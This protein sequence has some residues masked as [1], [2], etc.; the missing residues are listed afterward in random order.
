MKK[1]GV[2]TMLLTSITVNLCAQQ[3]ASDKAFEVP[4]NIIIHRKFD[5]NLDKGNKVV[6]EL[7]ALEDLERVSNVDSLLRIFLQDIAPLKDSMADAL[8]SRRI[9]YVTDAQGR[10]KM[11]FRQFTEKGASF[12]IKDGELAS[13]RTTQDTVHLIGI[14]NNAAP[15]KSE[16]VS[17]SLPRYYHYTFYLN[18]IDDLNALVGGPLTAK[19]NTLQNNING[20]WPLV[21]GTRSHYLK[22]DKTITADERRGTTMQSAGGGD[23]ITFLGSVNVQNYK[24]YFVPSLSLGAQFTFTNAQKTFKWVPGIYWEPHFLF[25]RD[26]ANKLRSFRNDF[27]T[28]TYAQGGT[29]GYDSKKDFS[30]STAFSLGYLIRRKGEYFEKNTF[31]LGAGSIQMKK[32]NVEPFIYFNNFFKGVTPGIRI[33]QFF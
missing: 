24:N 31:R 19:I 11:R 20:K 13:L 1:L 26:S 23:F 7:S 33:T 30:F 6:L 17:R 9:D 25:G 16:K 12:L 21:M 18:D 3:S 15:A 29:T 27:L 22:A 28:L 5:F 10:K 14:I 8:A 4:E 32:T 2:I